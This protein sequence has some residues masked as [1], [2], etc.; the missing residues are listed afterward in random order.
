M[1]A[2]KPSILGFL[3]PTPLLVWQFWLDF[4]YQLRC[5]GKDPQTVLN[6]DWVCT[7]SVPPSH[8]LVSWEFDLGLGLL[9][10]AAI[11]FVVQRLTRRDARQFSS[12]LGSASIFCTVSGFTIVLGRVVIL[13]L[14]HSLV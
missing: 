14:V 13:L 7:R 3:I 1:F 2:C 11:L 6:G 5:R 10:L 4:S 8:H 12:R 9:I